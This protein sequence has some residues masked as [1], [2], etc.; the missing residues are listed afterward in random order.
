MNPLTLITELDFRRLGIDHTQRFEQLNDVLGCFLQTVTAIYDRL[1]N[2]NNDV[3][4]VVKCFDRLEESLELRHR[5]NQEIIQ[6]NSKQQATALD[7]LGRNLH[8]LRGDFGS[9]FDLIDQQNKYFSRASHQ[10]ACRLSARLES[11]SKS[12]PRLSYTCYARSSGR[13]IHLVS[14]SSCRPPQKPRDLQRRKGIL[15]IA[16]VTSTVV[17]AIL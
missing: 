17:S 5:S 9:R 8:G 12:S 6:S 11:N 3:R 15:S 10:A 16:I 13:K 2:A 7:L 4:H 14:R 1:G